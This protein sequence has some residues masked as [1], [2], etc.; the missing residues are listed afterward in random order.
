MSNA[1]FKNQ[2]KKDLKKIASGLPELFDRSIVKRKVLG[3]ELKLTGF[4]KTID[5]EII[6]D[7]KIYDLP[8]PSMIPRN[9]YRRLKKIYESSG[10]PGVIDYIEKVKK[11]VTELENENDS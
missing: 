10:E 1:R 3:S 5:G 6:E 2:L 8:V 7:G 4:N 11:E 9:H